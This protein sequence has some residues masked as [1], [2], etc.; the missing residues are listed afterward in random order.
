LDENVGERSRVVLMRMHP[1]RRH[2]SDEV[3]RAPTPSHRLD[4]F[5]EC[6]RAADIATSDGRVDAGQ[7][8]HHET[9]GTDVEMSD[10]GI[11]HLPLR[12]ADI[13]T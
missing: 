1:A 7:V 2:Q 9:A 8:L 5:V 12:Q 4:Q 6:R 11:A 13:L 10:L 3:T